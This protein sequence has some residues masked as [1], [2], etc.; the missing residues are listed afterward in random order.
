MVV[1]G[2]E[3]GKY[4]TWKQVYNA[5]CNMT[6]LVTDREFVDGELRFKLVRILQDNEYD[7]CVVQMLR[8]TDKG[9]V[10]YYVAP[11]SWPDNNMCIRYGS[12]SINGKEYPIYSWQ[13]LEYNCPNKWAVYIDKFVADSRLSMCTLLSLLDTREEKEEVQFSYDKSLNVVGAYTTPDKFMGVMFCN[14]D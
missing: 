6:I 7:Y 3:E 9:L 11:N 5:L 1:R 8:N 13:D 2:I 14:L 4:Y 10:S 12:E